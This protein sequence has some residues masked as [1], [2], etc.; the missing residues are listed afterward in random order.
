[1]TQDNDIGHLTLD[2]NSD[3]NSDSETEGYQ[4]YYQGVG[5]GGV[6]PSARIPGNPL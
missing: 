5:G 6:S 3:S 4:G 1:M 2:G